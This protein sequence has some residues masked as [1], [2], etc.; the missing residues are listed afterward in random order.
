MIYLYIYLLLVLVVL[1][2][3]HYRPRPGHYLRCDNCGLVHKTTERPEF[4][5]VCDGC[6]RQTS[7]KELYPE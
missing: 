7:F 4:W 3:F 5:G 6:G 2:I 1:V